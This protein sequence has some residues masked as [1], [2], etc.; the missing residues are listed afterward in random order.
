MRDILTA[1]QATSLVGVPVPVAN[2]GQAE[3]VCSCM[4]KNTEQQRFSPLIWTNLKESSGVYACSQEIGTALWRGLVCRSSACVE[5]NFVQWMCPCVPGNSVYI[6]VA[7]AYL[8]LSLATLLCP[9]PAFMLTEVCIY[10]GYR[11]PAKKTCKYFKYQVFTG[12]E[13]SLQTYDL[14][15]FALPEQSFTEEIMI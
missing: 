9:W 8:C 14:P 10:T 12:T 1:S 3:A 7:C 13:A 2:S 15:C 11:C 6:R 5:G 4:R